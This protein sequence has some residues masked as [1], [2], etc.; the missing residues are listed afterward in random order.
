MKTVSISQLKA[1]LSEYL[2]A[3]RK[4][5]EVVVTDRGSPIA[6]ILKVE[7][8]RGQEERRTRLSRLGILSLRRGTLG[9]R[10]PPHGKGP[11]GVLSALLEEREEGR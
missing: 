11:A 5:E 3:V 1:S 7:G 10:K 8:V 2:D 6:R 9:K 4:G